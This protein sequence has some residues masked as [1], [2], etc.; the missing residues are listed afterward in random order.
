MQWSSITS[1]GKLVA[2]GESNDP[3]VMAFSAC[4]NVEDNWEVMSN[5]RKMMIPSF[6][7]GVPIQLVHLHDQG[8]MRS[9]VFTA[10]SNPI[11]AV[12]PDEKGILLATASTNIII[13][14]FSFLAFTT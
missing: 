12:C 14:P 2:M 5:G 13:A 10:H 4:P 6:K 1:L 11:S 7:L 9:V 3:T 8:L